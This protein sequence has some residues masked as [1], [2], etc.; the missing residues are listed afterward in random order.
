MITW[1]HIKRFDKFAPVIM[2]PHTTV[3]KFVQLV[4]DH[5]VSDE[6]AF[7]KSRATDNCFKNSPISTNWSRIYY[8]L[9]SYHWIVYQYQHSTKILPGFVI[10]K[11]HTM[12][13]Q[14]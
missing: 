11:S 14:I 12:N 10:I 9:A 3:H 8:H 5:T 1:I 2:H 7:E 13:N 6:K 4:H